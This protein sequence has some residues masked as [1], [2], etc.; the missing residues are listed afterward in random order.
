MWVKSKSESS[1]CDFIPLGICTIPSNVALT[2]GFLPEVSIYAYL[3]PSAAFDGPV[4]DDDVLP[5]I[6]GKQNIHCK[7]L[8]N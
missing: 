8:N 6:K 1:M 3:I 7:Y 5:Y 4:C 2:P